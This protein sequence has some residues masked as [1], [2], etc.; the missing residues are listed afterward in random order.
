MTLQAWISGLTQLS[1]WFAVG[2]VCFVGGGV[3]ERK[4]SSSH[5]E[6]SQDVVQRTNSVLADRAFK[7]SPDGKLLFIGRAV[8]TTYTVRLYGSDI[9]GLAG[10]SP[11][12]LVSMWRMCFLRRMR[13]TKQASFG[14]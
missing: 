2:V 3:S 12:S 14:R 8:H 11:T 4:A 9:E 10:S 6:R 7:I 5:A 1:I 13:M